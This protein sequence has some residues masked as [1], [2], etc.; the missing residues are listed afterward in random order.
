[1][2]GQPQ[3]EQ[4]WVDELQQKCQEAMDDDLN[5]PIVISHLFDACK[6]INTLQDRKA[7]ITPEVAQALT[8]VFRTWAVDILG[9]QLEAA[10]G[11]QEREQAFGGAVDLLLQMRA[12]AKEA[13][14]WATSD[15]IRDQ[16]A[17]LGFEVKDTKDGAT[18][19]L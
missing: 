5:S 8:S 4:A 12:K 10:A 9:L 13:K 15:Q 17:Q 16:L 14:D 7:S 3:V 1:M 11:S 6:T 19:K 2:K 18:W